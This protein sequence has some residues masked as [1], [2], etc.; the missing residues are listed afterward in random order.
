M[1]KIMVKQLNLKVLVLAI[2]CVKYIRA[3]IGKEL[4]LAFS[5]KKEIVRSYVI[6]AE[7]VEKRIYEKK[8]SECNMRKILL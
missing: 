3:A 6:E 5:G 8:N 7:M 1:W 4:E 2:R